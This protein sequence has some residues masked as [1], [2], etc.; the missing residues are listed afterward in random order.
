MP[1]TIGRRSLFFGAIAVVCVLL[2]PFTP[3]ELRWVDWSAACLG[4]F[5]A[6]LFAIEDSLR[7]GEPGKPKD[8]AASIPQTESPFGPPPRPGR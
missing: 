7:P 8:S 2:V 4:G 3:G 1:R 6:L 5:W